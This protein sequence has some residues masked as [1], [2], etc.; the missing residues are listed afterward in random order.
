MIIIIKDDR[1]LHVACRETDLDRHVLTFGHLRNMS[2]QF[3][4]TLT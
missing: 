1:K 4:H 3:N 2:W